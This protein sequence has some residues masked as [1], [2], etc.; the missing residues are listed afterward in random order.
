M[1]D[2]QTANL[3]R[4]RALQDDPYPY[5]DALRAQPHEQADLPQLQFRGFFEKVD[6]P[7][8]GA[9]RHSTVPFRLS[10]GPERFHR[11]PAPLLG[12]HTDEVLRGL[13]ISDDELAE[14]RD[15]GVIG[16]V[17]DAWRPTRS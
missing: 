3:F 1:I 13:G 10:R 14:L 4:D 15:L 5:F 16:T 2:L 11:R 8:T 7:L 9:A 6:R 12:E 17:P